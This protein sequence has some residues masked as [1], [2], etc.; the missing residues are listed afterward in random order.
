MIY[1]E[2]AAGGSLEERVDTSLSPQSRGGE[3]AG[4]VWQPT[5]HQQSGGCAISIHLNSL[6]IFIICCIN[7]KASG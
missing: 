5:K 7:Y 4:R 1:A 2:E 3:A 6:N